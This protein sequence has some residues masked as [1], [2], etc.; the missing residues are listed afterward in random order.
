VATGN[1]LE[2]ALDRRFI[3]RH[4]TTE[5]EVEQMAEPVT[6]AGMGSG[7]M[8]LIPSFIKIGSAIEKLI[9]DDT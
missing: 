9:G 6:A 7:V 8:I 2:T 3:L 1:N 4:H 5:V